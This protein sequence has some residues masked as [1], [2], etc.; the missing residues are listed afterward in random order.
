[1]VGMR[2]LGTLADP[3]ILAKLRGAAAHL[4]IKSIRDGSWFQSVMRHHLRAHTT[5][6][7]EKTS[8]VKEHGLGVDV[9]DRAHRQVQRVAIKS[10][11]AGAIASAATSTGEIISLLTEGLAAPVGLPGAALAMALE[12]AYTS[13]LQIDLACDVAMLYGVPFNPDDHG[14]LATLFGLALD[15]D[16]YSK[17]QKEEEDAGGKPH[18]LF[19]RLMHLEEGEIGT[20]IGRKLL[21]ESMLRNVLPIVGVPISA[22]WNYM[23]T[24][25]FGNKVKK[26][27]R[28]RRA[29]IDS[30]ERLKLAGLDAK[31]LVQGAWLLSIS[32]GE[33]GHEEM[34]ALSALIDLLPETDRTVMKNANGAL[35]DDE[36]GYLTALAPFGEK[37]GADAHTALLDALY[38][39]A[40]SD[41]EL[42]VPERRFLE[43]VGTALGQKADLGR[44]EQICGHLAKGHP[45]P[46]AAS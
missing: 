9:D 10:A 29:L 5:G 27:V 26:Y 36:A 31:L 23:A 44:V 30:I 6:Q 4:G 15:L 37:A 25:R 46:R 20:R 34:L 43:R 13:L 3:A 11:A 19:A 33:A 45:L 32:D 1:M 18:G 38:L 2:G 16:V 21:E 14:E 40:A 42:T 22:R 12:A 41:H 35:G 28:G 7:M 39:V 17:K 8:D 24:V